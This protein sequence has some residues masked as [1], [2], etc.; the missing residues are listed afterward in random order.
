MLP[1]IDI[2]ST[3][4][5]TAISCNRNSTAYLL[6]AARSLYDL[7]RKLVGH[8]SHVLKSAIIRLERREVSA[9]DY[10]VLI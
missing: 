9:F 8:I 2:L 6:R 1:H 10:E 4:A 3:P 5:S 7:V